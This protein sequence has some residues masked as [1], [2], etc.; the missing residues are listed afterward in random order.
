MHLS[1]M[2][3]GL[4]QHQNDDNEPLNV[5]PCHMYYD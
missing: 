1:Q 5:H 4:K 3:F 2:S